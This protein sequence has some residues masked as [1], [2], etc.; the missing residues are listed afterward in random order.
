VIMCPV[1]VKTNISYGLGRL[2][3]TTQSWENNSQERKVCE[4]A[5]NVWLKIITGARKGH[6]AQKQRS[7]WCTF[8]YVRRRD[9]RIVAKTTLKM[10]KYPLYATRWQPLCVHNKFNT[11]T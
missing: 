9:M 5:N 10:A 6:C 2:H 8:T 7:F 3:I 4:E 11:C 1:R